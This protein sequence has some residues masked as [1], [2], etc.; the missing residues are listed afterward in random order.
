ME[1]HLTDQTV[2]KGHMSNMEKTIAALK[3]EIGGKDSQM[4]ILQEKV[5][6]SDAQVRDLLSEVEKKE[7]DMKMLAECKDELISSLKDKLK[8]NET[9]MSRFENEIHLLSMEKTA[10]KRGKNMQIKTLRDNLKEK[11]VQ[12]R[13]LLLQKKCKD[14][15][16]LEHEK[17]LEDQ[18]RDKQQ[19]VEALT[20][21]NAKV[22]KLEHKVHNQAEYASTLERKA[23]RLHLTIKAQEREIGQLTLA[24]GQRPSEVKEKDKQIEKLREKIEHG[25]TD[26][27]RENTELKKRIE[28]LREKVECDERELKTENNK[29]RKWIE[30]L[31]EKNKM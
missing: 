23:E 30:K 7:L 10:L 1:W 21:V 11:D 6:K 14:D 9:Q 19:A 17:H 4:K 16:F 8:A 3:K 2:F 26:L 27:K 13:S 15:K 12:V 5:N 28:K 29:L 24:V 22:A 20:V 31:R 18:I 25:E